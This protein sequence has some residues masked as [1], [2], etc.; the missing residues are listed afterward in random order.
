[1]QDSFPDIPPVTRASD[2]KIVRRATYSFV[3]IAFLAVVSLGAYIFG[4]RNSQPSRVLG[5]E[6]LITPTL[7]P[8]LPPIPTLIPTTP[9]PTP[10]IKITL[11]PLPKNLHLKNTQIVPIATP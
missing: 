3:F 6:T 10:K 4:T 1:M 9:T 8:T 11:A 7:Y 5:T 2:K